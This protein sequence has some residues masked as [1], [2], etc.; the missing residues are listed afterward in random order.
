MIQILASFEIVT[1][2]FLCQLLSLP[3]MGK[4]YLLEK[5]LEVLDIEAL[6]MWEL[7]KLKC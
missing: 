6:N 5:S 1:K 3:E 4:Y 7:W 2:P